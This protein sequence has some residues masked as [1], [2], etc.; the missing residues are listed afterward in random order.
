MGS[1]DFFKL[2]IHKIHFDAILTSKLEKK[3][4]KIFSQLLD[5]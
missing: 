3:Y 2:L 1:K 5:K 4:E